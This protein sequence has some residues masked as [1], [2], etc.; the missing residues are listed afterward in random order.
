VIRIVEPQTAHD[1]DMLARDW[2]QECLHG[3]HARA[4]LRVRVERGR[5]EDLARPDLPL[6]VRG[7]ADVE[8]G[9][10]G[11]AEVHL[12]GLDGD[13]ADQARPRLEQVGG[14]AQR[15]GGA[16]TVLIGGMVVVCEIEQGAQRGTR[17]Q[18]GRAIAPCGDAEGRKQSMPAREA[19]R[20]DLDI[21]PTTCIKQHRRTH[22]LLAGVEPPCEVPAERGE[23]D[24]VHRSAP[25]S[26]HAHS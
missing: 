10:D 20:N 11:L 2:G 17:R 5:A 22:G 16:L 3:E 9:V 12:R 4:E 25:T 24:E 26:V 13:E 18:R 23:R 8:R 1:S 15:G 21:L 7:A 14:R 6:L 19:K